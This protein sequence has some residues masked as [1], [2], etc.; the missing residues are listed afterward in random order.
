MDRLEAMR[1]F[2]RVAEAGSFSAV[3]Q[4]LGIARSIVTRQVAALESH[5]RTKLI[6]RSTRRLSLTSA[7][8]DYLEKCR[9]ILNL[10]DVA[11]SGV[12]ADRQVPRGP[13]RMSVPLSF[14]MRHVL[15]R[16]LEFARRYAEVSLNVDYIDRRS[17]LIEE[18]ID[19]AIRITRHL[20][21]GDITRRISSSRVL[22]VGSPEYL[23]RHGEPRH[24]ADLVHHECLAYTGTTQP[25]QWEFFVDGKAQRYPIRARLQ[26]N[27]GD[28]LIEA[29]AAGFGLTITPEFM[30]AEA[31]ASGRVR[32]TLAGFPLAELGIYLVLPSNRHVPHRVRVLMDFLAERLGPQPPWTAAAPAKEKRRRA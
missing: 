25:G 11:E 13:I 5:L 30:A 4:Q 16:L 1:Q 21:T 15:P 24:P 22:V 20:E 17:K 27:N 26:A 2:V 18:G 19:L 31:I 7:G 32:Q 14:G 12:A 8:A 9:V 29:A 6:A 3:A 23:A 10:V 28:A